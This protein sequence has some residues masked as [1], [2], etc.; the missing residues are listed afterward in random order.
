MFLSFPEIMLMLMYISLLNLGLV[1]CWPQPFLHMHNPF[2]FIL[3]WLFF[4]NIDVFCLAQTH[5]DTTH[6]T[7]LWVQF[8]YWVVILQVNWTIWFVMVC[9]YIMAS[10]SG[11][12]ISESAHL[13]TVT[14]KTQTDDIHCR[15]WKATVHF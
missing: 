12:D 15:I 8:R 13:H 1:I 2:V 10:G 4:L 5:P 3:F 9:F 7:L 6:F 11:H 14:A